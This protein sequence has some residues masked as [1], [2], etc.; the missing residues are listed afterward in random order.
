MKAIICHGYG[1]PSDVLSIEDID[2]PEVGDHDV[3]VQVHAAC[4]NPADWHLIRGV[5]YVARLQ[6]GLRRPSFTIPGSDFAG[7]VTAIGEAVSEVRVGDDVFGTTFM[8]GFGAFAEHLVVPEAVLAPKPDN[9]SFDEAAAVPLAALTALQGLRDHGRIENGQK[10]LVIGASGGVGT[11]AVQIAKYF[12]AEVTGACSTRNVDLVRS[13]GADHVIDY[14]T[15][16]AWDEADQY[17]LILH[18]AGGQTASDLRRRL[19]SEGTLV[20]ISG[21]S[22]NRWFGP[23]G[24]IIAG[25]L[26]SRFVSQTITTFTVQPNRDDLKLLASLI[27]GGTLRPVV[28]TT[29]P[30]GQFDDAIRHVEEG[31]THGKVVLNVR[32]AVGTASAQPGQRAARPVRDQAPLDRN[33]GSVPVQGTDKVQH[34]EFPQFYR[35]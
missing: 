25:Q 3:L 27:E 6:V 8:L 24:R 9:V 20:Q 29:Y 17:D 32:A 2:E 11:F 33:W 30:L 4:I 5:P 34:D 28:D 18:V 1:A 26:L 23:I 12:G 14:T 13:L 15:P 35:S 10:V 19:T 21:D 16:G 31:H 7:R 22:D